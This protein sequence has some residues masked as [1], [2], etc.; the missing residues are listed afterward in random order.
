MGT[1]YAYPSAAL[2]RCGSG[3]RPAVIEHGEKGGA[4]QTYAHRKERS[5]ERMKSAAD[6]GID[7][8]GGFDRSKKR[9]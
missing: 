5:C 6:G 2:A 8:S 7:V 9:S 4:G 1:Q 3:G